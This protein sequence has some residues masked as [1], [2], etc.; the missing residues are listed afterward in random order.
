MNV[1]RELVK[2]VL[3]RPSLIPQGFISKS[4]ALFSLRR[5]VC[6]VTHRQSTYLAYE[7]PSLISSTWKQTEPSKPTSLCVFQGGFAFVALAN[8]SPM[9]LRS[10]IQ[11]KRTWNGTQAAFKP[12]LLCGTEWRERNSEVQWAEDNPMENS[13]HGFTEACRTM[14][15]P[16]SLNSSQRHK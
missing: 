11:R 16:G 3:C 1:R 4:M 6:G 14:Q 8:V 15:R 9:V 7:S 2:S 13:P 12:N 10:K 5:S